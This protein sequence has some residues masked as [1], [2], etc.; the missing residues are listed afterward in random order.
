MQCKT[1]F[2]KLADACERG[3]NCLD[4]R[5]KLPMWTSVFTKNVHEMRTSGGDKMLIT[6]DLDSEQQSILK[7][8]S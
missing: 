2:M 1:L 4:P 8:F 6:R 5:A 7:Q 3:T